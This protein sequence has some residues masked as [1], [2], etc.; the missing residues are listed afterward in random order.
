MT[1]VVPSKTPETMSTLAP[2]AVV[3]STA[4]KLRL[5]DTKRFL[6][7]SSCW[8]RLPMVSGKRFGAHG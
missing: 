6:A 3:V 1:Y 4:N 5:L 7:C 8:F 2:A